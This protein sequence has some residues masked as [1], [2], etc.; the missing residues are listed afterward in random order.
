[1]KVAPPSVRCRASATK[2]RM[3]LCGGRRYD[4]A[5]AVSARHRRL[6]DAPGA[7]GS[8]RVERGGLSGGG[9]G[10]HATRLPARPSGGLPKPPTEL[11][12]RGSGHRRSVVRTV[13]PDRRRRAVRVRLLELLGG[14]S[15]PRVDAR[16]GQCLRDA[17]RRC[18]AAFYGRSDCASWLARVQGPGKLRAGPPWWTS[19]KARVSRVGSRALCD[20]K[21]HCGSCPL[22]TTSHPTVRPS[23]RASLRPGELDREPIVG[24][25]NRAVR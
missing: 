19:S 5:R 2:H 22:T 13:S 12:R 7:R 1:M 17:P 4:C 24:R 15:K 3:S 23:R 16:S 14:V 11:E 9:S 8:G 10:I 21:T 25:R 18:G 20:K 6:R